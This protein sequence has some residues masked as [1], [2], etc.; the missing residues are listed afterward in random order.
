MTHRTPDIFLQRAGSNSSVCRRSFT[1]GAASLAALAVAGCSGRD[2]R[3]FRAADAQPDGY[4]TVEAVEAMGRFLNERSGGRL[5]LKT[6]AGGQ[7]GAE[8][9]TLEITIF[10]GLD[11]NRIS[12]A[13]LGAVAADWA[14]V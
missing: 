5:S 4:P 3:V 2:R 13:P 12:I 9:D 10:G 14:G 7:L 8:S 1:A 11:F 6:Y